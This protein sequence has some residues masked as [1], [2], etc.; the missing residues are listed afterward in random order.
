MGGSPAPLPRTGGAPW[1]A[2]AKCRAPKSNVSTAEVQRGIG[3]ACR[4]KSH[5]SRT[6]GTKLE[7]TEGRVCN[8]LQARHL[9]LAERVG[10]VPDEP[11]PINELGAIESARTAQI[12]SN[13][14]YSRYKTGT[15]QLALSGV[16][17]RRALQRLMQVALGPQA[18]PELRRR[19]QPLVQQD[20][21]GPGRS[22]A[23]CSPRPCGV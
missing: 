23:D 4:S 2:T 21:T 5:P 19:L 8:S 9:E 18:R 3:N 22:H 12:H 7:Q 13:P 10:F 20:V 1:R 17:S 6:T 11:A 14:E 15:A 16:P